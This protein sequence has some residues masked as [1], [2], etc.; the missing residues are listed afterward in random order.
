MHPAVT[1]PDLGD[2][3]RPPRVRPA[4]A[5]A[6]VDQALGGRRTALPDARM[7][8]AWRGLRCPWREE[9]APDSV[10][11]PHPRT[12]MPAVTGPG[13]MMVAAT[14]GERRPAGHTQCGENVGRSRPTGP[15]PPPCVCLMVCGLV[16]RVIVVR[17]SGRI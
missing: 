6:T 5:E 15:G 2:A 10:P 9:E 11:L 4:G 1:G 14:Q 17:V 16:V 7:P 8:G 13:V 3:G 12:R